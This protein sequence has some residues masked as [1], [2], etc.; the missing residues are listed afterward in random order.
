LLM[1]LLTLH[2]FFLKPFTNRVSPEQDKCQKM[3]QHLI[4]LALFHAHISL[5]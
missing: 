3:L 1:L 5:C 2:F 4:F